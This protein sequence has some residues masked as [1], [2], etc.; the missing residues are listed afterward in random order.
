MAN[1]VNEEKFIEWYESVS[2]EK[3]TNKS[4]LLSDALTHFS[5]TGESVFRIPAAKSVTGKEETYEYRV[6]NMGCCGAST[7]YLYF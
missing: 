3:L 6:E 4:Q 7:I 2:K 5:N 1:Y